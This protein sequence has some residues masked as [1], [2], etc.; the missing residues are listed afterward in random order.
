MAKKSGLSSAGGQV[1]PNTALLQ[2][3]RENAGLRQELA[4]SKRLADEAITSLREFEA[5][6]HYLSI[7]DRDPIP[8]DLLES[9]RISGESTAILVLSDWHWEE[10]VDPA[11]VNGKNSYSPAIAAKRAKGMFQRAAGIIDLIRGFTTINEL[12]IAVLGDMITGYIHEELEENNYLSPSEALLEVQEHLVSGIEFLRKETK[13]KRIIIPTAIGNHG[14]T[15]HKKRIS[16]SYKNS[17]EWL[18]YSWLAWHYRGDPVVRWQ[19][20]RGY[21][22]MLDIQGHKVRFHH[23]DHINYQGGVGGI[24]IPVNKAIAAWNKTDTAALDIFGHF[25]QSKEDRWWVS[26]GSLI[27]LNAYSVAI[28]ADYEEPSQSLVVISRKRGK[29]INTR[30]FCE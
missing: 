19:V 10:N 5:R 28:K 13:V 20:G 23:G 26:N 4:R 17:F 1:D 7:I 14:R 9:R 2:A 21:H 8:Y 18:L 11:V 6:S 24:S 30:V 27:G 12:V 25:H 3:A 29:I 15:Q 22:N 16:T